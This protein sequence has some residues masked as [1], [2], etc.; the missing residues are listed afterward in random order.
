MRIH[1]TILS[2][3]C[4]GL[5]ACGARPPMVLIPEVNNGAG[6]REHAHKAVMPPVQCGSAGI[7]CTTE[8]RSAVEQLVRGHLDFQ[9][10]SWVG[11]EELRLAARA[12]S[13]RTVEDNRRQTTA[14]ESQRATERLLGLPGSSVRTTTE[15]ASVTRDTLLEGPGFE[16]LPPADREALLRQVGAD[17][18]VSTR[19]VLGAAPT[20]SHGEGDVE[21]FVRYSVDYGA[22]LVWASKCRAFPSSSGSLEAA[23]SDATRCAL[24]RSQYVR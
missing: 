19:V 9:G 14:T 21:V 15:S 16:D 6:L 10:L 8:H 11:S 23:I 17:A 12:R 5:A 1:I 22:T 18:L 13:E 4:V 7:P 3:L 24:S 2:A 20:L